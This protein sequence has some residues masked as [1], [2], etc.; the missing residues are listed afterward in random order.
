MPKTE[1]QLRHK[2][3]NSSNNLLYLSVLAFILISTTAIA[4]NTDISDVITYVYP[5]K[6]TKAYS[7]LPVLN[8]NAKYPI[9]SAQSVMA[10]DL[11]SG[12]TLYEKDPNKALLP[13]S[14]TK[15]LTALVAIDTYELE[16]VLK[17]GRINVEGQK[18]GLVAGEEIKFIDLL[19][20]LLIYSANDA[21]EVL[22]QNHPG[23]RALFIGL[24]N[25]KVKDLGLTNSH[26]TNPVGLD[27]GAQYSTARD[28][29]VVAKYAMQNSL[30]SEIVGTKE[31]IVKS[32]DGKFI[33]RLINLNKLLGT[34]EGVKGVKTGW[35]EN[36]RENLVTYVE[37]DNRK[38]MI[39]VLGSSDRFG[40]TKELV[41]WVYSNYKWEEVKP[42]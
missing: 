1:I 4:L 34:V 18:M 26:F 41:E 5:Q 17:V 20:G 24:M 23:G 8:E 42:E 3:V 21:A 38:V 22:A 33:H 9:L 28:L 37:R 16:Q 2:K 10:V 36:A 19:N 29:I 25:K 6:I 40:E 27:D 35:T 12:V 15:I 14:T 31:K 32:V 11:T 7:D 30:F 13:A 39:V